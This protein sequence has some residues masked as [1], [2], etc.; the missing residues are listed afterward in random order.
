[1]ENLRFMVFN[2]IPPPFPIHGKGGG[3]GG[4]APV[5]PL[6]MAQPGPPVKGKP[7]QGGGAMHP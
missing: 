5:T 4:Y 3:S 1:M 7:P 2:P 6:R